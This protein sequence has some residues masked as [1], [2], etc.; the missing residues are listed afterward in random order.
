MIVV[1]VYT[2]S[3]V[4]QNIITQNQLTFFLISNPFQQSKEESYQYIPTP[5]IDVGTYGID[6]IGRLSIWDAAG[7]IEYHMTH[8]MFLGGRYSIVTV[9]YDLREENAL[10]VSV[11]LPQKVLK[12]RSI[13][14]TD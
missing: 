4:K 13:C 2:F 5:G 12:R 9:V 7:H 11:I 10:K 8:G 1:T 6:G 3:Q 14:I